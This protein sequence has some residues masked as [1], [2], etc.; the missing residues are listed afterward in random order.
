[1]INI[2]NRFVVCFSDDETQFLKKITKQKHTDIVVV[3]RFLD[4]V[5]QIMKLP[6]LCA[7]SVSN[8]FIITQ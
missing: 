1:M 2:Y 3:E 7:I 5:D 8:M 6:K 4:Q